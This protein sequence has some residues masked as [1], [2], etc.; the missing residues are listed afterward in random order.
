LLYDKVINDA[1]Y[2][3]AMKREVRDIEPQPLSSVNDQLNDEK[4]VEEILRVIGKQEI[5]DLMVH[6]NIVFYDTEGHGHD[7]SDPYNAHEHYMRWKE[8]GHDK[9]LHAK[10]LTCPLSDDPMEY[11]ISLDGG[12]TFKVSL[13]NL[14]KIF[15]EILDGSVLCCYS[16]NGCDYKRL[17]ALYKHHYKSDHR[18]PSFDCLDLYATVGKEIVKSHFG[19][20]LPNAKLFTIYY[21]LI[22]LAGSETPSVPYKLISDG[23]KC[24]FDTLALRLFHGLLLGL[25][26][27]PTSR[28]ES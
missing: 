1:T 12:E 16:N 10:L 9:S 4:V 3:D 5:K 15:D 8:N 23:L 7:L 2:V 28:T 17:A 25:L 27:N 13:F 18:M 14:L 20:R 21:Y 19:L 26:S 24:Q 22:D 11:D 6:E